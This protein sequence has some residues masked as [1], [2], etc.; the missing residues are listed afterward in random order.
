MNENIMKIDGVK[1][2]LEFLR[3]EV[4]IEADR[5]LI[6]TDE[7]A[8][9]VGIEA[10]V[11]VDSIKELRVSEEYVVEDGKLEKIFTLRPRPT[12]D[13]SDTWNQLWESWK[14]TFNGRK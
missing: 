1:E 14:K 9:S 10:K 2:L 3:K 13:L 12:S 11:S 6:S 8:V 7:P 5:F 4:G